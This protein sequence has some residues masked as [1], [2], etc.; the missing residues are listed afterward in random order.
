MRQSDQLVGLGVNVR[1][2]NQCAGEAEGAVLHGLLDEGLH[3]LQLGRRRGA[4]V[5]AN[6]SFADL[7][8]AD[9]RADVEWRALFFETAEIAIKRCP[10][11]C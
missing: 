1:W 4:I 6:H 11:D 5:V 3:L 8:R 7:C 2:I 9:V 10:I